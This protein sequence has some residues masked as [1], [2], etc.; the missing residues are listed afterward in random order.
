NCIDTSTPPRKE[1]LMTDDERLARNMAKLDAQRAIRERAIAAVQSQRD[2]AAG[3]R[4][5]YGNPP[6][7]KRPAKKKVRRAVATNTARDP[8]D[9]RLAQEAAVRR[10]RIVE[11]YQEGKE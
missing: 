10:A 4:D 3:R 9:N 2:T 1:H 7:K 6:T 8:R 5:E 11:L